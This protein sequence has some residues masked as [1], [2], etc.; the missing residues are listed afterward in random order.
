MLPFPLSKIPLNIFGAG[1]VSCYDS[2]LWIVQGE[3]C[4]SWDLWMPPQTPII[5]S[6]DNKWKKFGIQGRPKKRQG[7]M[8]NSSC[9]INMDGSHLYTKATGEIKEAAELDNIEDSLP[10]HSSLSKTPL[11]LLLPFCTLTASSFHHLPK[12]FLNITFNSRGVQS[13][14][15]PRRGC[16]GSWK[17]I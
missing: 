10:R 15:S 4:C 2:V 13:P 3:Q 17:A 16:S 5:S 11:D 9:I 8:W 6:S 14:R 12:L 7:T 1:T